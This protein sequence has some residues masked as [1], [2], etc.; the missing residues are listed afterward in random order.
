MDGQGTHG[1]SLTFQVG[2]HGLMLVL[3]LGQALGLLLLF[4]EVGSKFGYSVF[5]QF[6]LLQVEKEYESSVL[7]ELIL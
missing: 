5:Q 4:H 6:L 3:E 7:T 1:Q 2:D